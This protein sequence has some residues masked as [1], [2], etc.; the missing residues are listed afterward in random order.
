[1]NL[2]I[3]LI[4]TDFDGTIF[5]EFESPP[6]PEPLQDIIGD[7][8]RRG[9]KWAINTGRDMSSLMEALARSKVSIQPDYLVLVERE[10]HIHDGVRYA[11][12]EQWN[13]ACL[14]AH[15]ELFKRVREDVPR[16]TD[17]INARFHATVY[18]DDYSPFCLI[19]GD[20]GDADLIHEYL[21]EYCR[22]VP[23]L[24]LMRN[25]VYARFSH[26]SYNK[27]T[28]LQELSRRLG[29]SA[30]TVFAAGDHLNDLPM[31]DRK[32]ARW[33]AAPDNAIAPVK[34]MVLR[35][36]GFIS[37]LPAGRGVAE[38]IMFHLKNDAGEP[39]LL[40]D[41]RGAMIKPNHLIL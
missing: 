17:W 2:P 15:Q 34:N 28:A 4:S 37:K 39:Y 41:D 33:L 8:Q 1:M 35:Q 19:A 36:S 11:G 16:L 10:I 26:E 25:D 32:Y 27:G 30:D 20:N 13:E 14:Q 38:A 23:H 24:A 9:V 22:E 21:D 6:I 7:L 5:S 12:L 29:I 3:R 18:E 31:L 40:I